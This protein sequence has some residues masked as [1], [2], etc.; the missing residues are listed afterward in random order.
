MFDGKNILDLSS[1]W[2]DRLI[3]CLSIEQNIKHYIGIDPNKNLFKNYEK[4]ISDLSKN[5]DKYLLINKPSQDVEFLNF[6]ERDFI[7]WS[8]PFEKQELYIVDKSREDYNNQSVNT[9]TTY[10]VWESN[11]LIYTINQSVN[12]LKLNG[13]LILYLGNIKYDSF[14]KKM[15][16]IKKIKFINNISIKTGDKIKNYMIYVK[17]QN[18]LHVEILKKNKNENLLHKINS[19]T[20]FNPSPVIIQLN[21]KNKN[22]NLIQDAYLIAGTK[23]RVCIDYVKKIIEKNNK[24]DTITYAGSYNG[25]GAVACAFAAYVLKIKCKIFISKIGTGY[26][27]QSNEQQILNSRQ[28]ITLQTLNADVYLCDDYRTCKN[29]QYDFSDS[30]TKNSYTT[31]EN[32]YN[33]P[34]GLNDS[35]MVDLLSEKFKELKLN[36]IKRLFLVAGSGGILES[37]YKSYPN[38]EYY[39]YLTG[40]GKYKL[41]VL[42]FIKNKNNIHLLDENLEDVDNTYYSSVKNYD[43]KIIKFVYKY[44]MNDD[45]I[46]NVASDDFLLT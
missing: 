2:G 35:I 30:L 11:F 46:W 38:I 32:Y 19:I 33:V 3:A 20:N 22:I 12:I 4:M 5:K 29:L 28:I 45:Y 39:V 42:D 34:M 1:G 8:P 10:D 40:G 41:K 15:N 13:V 36:F 14:I 27:K 43:D 23:T 9:F 25:F 17:I 24:I 18:S 7:F 6:D 16:Q 37:L 44:G 21:I 26:N 31:K